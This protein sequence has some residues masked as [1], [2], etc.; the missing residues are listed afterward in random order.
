MENVSKPKTTDFKTDI[1]FE[2]LSQ[3]KNLVRAVIAGVI[4]V[5]IIVAIAVTIKLFLFKEGLMPANASQIGQR[6]ACNGESATIPN[7]WYNSNFIPQMN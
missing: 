7:Q 6:I 1:I 3:P 4:I 2:F 5:L